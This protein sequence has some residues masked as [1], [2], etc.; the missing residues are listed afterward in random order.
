MRHERATEEIRELTALYALGSLTQREARSFELH[1]NEGC[2]VCEAE[3]RKF[4]H[5]AAGIGFTAAEV[6][7]PDYIRDLLFGPH[8]A[9]TSNRSNRGPA[10]PAQ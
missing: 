5:A 7:P 10:E 1:M 8:R 9:R 2:S 3:F 4:K 6:A